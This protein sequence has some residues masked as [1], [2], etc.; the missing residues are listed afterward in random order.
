MIHF[1]GAGPGDP[2]LITVKGKCLLERADLIIYT[3]SLV[4]P[5]LLANAKPGCK[6]YDSA[7]MTLAEVVKVMEAGSRRGEAIVR[8][9]TGDPSLFG[10]V[11]EQQDALTQRNIPY[12]VVPGVSSFAAAAAALKAEYTLPGVSQ[13]VILTR[14]AGRTPVPA[15]ESLESLAAHQ[16]SLVVFL[17]IRQIE[18][19][20]ARLR[21]HYPP[22]TP[23][24]VVYKASWPEEKIIRGALDNIAASVRRA[25][26][27]KTALLVVGDFLGSEYQLSKLYDPTFSHEYRKGSQPE[28]QC[29]R[30]RLAVVALTKNGA[31]IAD[32]IA[33][34]MTADLFTEW[35]CH[36]IKS[37]GW[38]ANGNFGALVGGLFEKYEGLIF[39]MACGIVVRSIAPFLQN[40]KADPAV[41]IVDEKGGH[42]ISLLSGHYGG[43]NQLARQIASLIG[44][45]AV[46]TTATD[47][48][49]VMAFD[50]FARENECVIENES[51]LKTISAALV[52][53][54]TVN[55]YTP[56]RLRGELPPQI[57]PGDFPGNPED[58]AVVLD[59]NLGN[60]PIARQVLF[61]RPKNLILG[62]GCKKGTSQ[63]AIA[64]AVAD[65]LQKYRRSFLSVKKLVS[66]EL[67]ANETGILEYCRQCDLIFQ[68]LSADKLAVIQSRLSSSAF[69][70]QTVGVGNVA[71]A[72][73]FLGGNHPRLICGKTVYPGIT[74]ALTEEEREFQL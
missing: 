59:N 13:T 73:A 67:K 55:L 27:T 43:A 18:E 58:L 61:I 2:E 37:V 46:I 48:N 26:I 47:L 9:H 5:A 45:E 60:H 8:L 44:G 54:E 53:G 63:A 1:V 15:S 41:V 40:K 57:R 4:N 35:D 10:A 70:K 68:T 30:M 34:K 72:C 65:F 52:N 20:V 25:N 6:I 71:E 64:G 39:I 56:Y 16:A 14:M 66:I 3:G 50:L 38:P 19:L 32:Q 69:V 12:E 21:T 11:R 29:G 42:V 62:I 17:S 23:A 28:K 22:K 31:V 33:A 74:L 24:A 49:R 36:G 51:E 7:G